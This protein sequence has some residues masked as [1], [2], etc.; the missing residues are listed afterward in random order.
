MRGGRSPLPMPHGIGE[1]FTLKR[2]EA[3]ANVR[4]GQAPLPMPAASEIIFPLK[5]R[6]A[7]A[8]VRGGRSPLPMPTASE[9]T[10]T[11]KC[12]EARANVRGGQAPLP[13]PA[14]SEIIFLLK[15][16]WSNRSCVARLAQTY[17]TGLPG[18]A[19]DLSFGL[20]AASSFRP[21]A[22]STTDRR[23]N[24]STMAR[25]ASGASGFS[26]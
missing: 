25:R 3:R 1:H 26:T 15:L 2:R 23:G 18:F 16:R 8:N 20:Q 5:C 4:G 10:F 14:A 24:C 13:M 22:F 12:R 6:E 17:A 11:L 19:L 7:R 9:I 21:P